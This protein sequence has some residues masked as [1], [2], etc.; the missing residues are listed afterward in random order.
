MQS[1]VDF[2]LIRKYDPDALRLIA[3][4]RSGYYLAKRIADIFASLILLVISFPLMLLI[5]LAIKIYSPGPIFFKQERVG[6]KRQTRGKSSYWKRVTFRCYKFRTMH[7]NADSSVHQ[8]YI[9]ALINNDQEQIRTL[10]GDASS[11]HKLVHDSRITR[12]GKLL[13]KLSLDELP[14]FFNVLIGDMSLVGPRPAIPYEVAM[15]KPWHLQR[16][17]VQP[18]ITGLQQVTSRSTA[19]FDEQVRLDIDYI[20]RQSVWLDIMIILKTPFV[21]LSTRG[22]G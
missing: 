7:H 16:L 3:K 15:Y 22:A 13:R 12:P 10:Q 19:N 11:I 5:A 18:G 9:K 8:A 17:E 21:I 2:E 6:S 14:Q 4:D 20:H 1:E